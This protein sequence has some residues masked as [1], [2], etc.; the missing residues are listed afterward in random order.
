MKDYYFFSFPSRIQVE[1]SEEDIQV[2]EVSRLE[3]FRLVHQ[4]KCDSE[5]SPDIPRDGGMR[6]LLLI[7]A[8][9]LQT[10]G[11]EEVADSFSKRVEEQTF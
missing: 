6:N 9:S 11:G 4:R 1:S 2:T 7:P 10:E 5:G 3:E 8:L